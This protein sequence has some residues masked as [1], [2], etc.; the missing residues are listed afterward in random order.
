MLSPWSIQTWMYFLLLESLLFCS[1]VGF[2]PT[3]CVD[4]GEIGQRSS[5][6]LSSNYRTIRD[7]VLYHDQTKCRRFPT[8]TKRF[9]RD[10]KIFVSEDPSIVR[11]LLGFVSRSNSNDVEYTSNYVRF[12]KKNN[13]MI[14]TGVG[15][16]LVL[17]DKRR[18][19]QWTQDVAK[20]FPWIPT[21]MLSV[22]ADGLAT[23]FASVAPKDLK[24]AL[25]PGGLEKTRSK[26]AGD[27]VRNLQGQPLI[28]QLPL[29]KEEKRKLLTGLVDFSLDFLLKDVEPAMASPFDK[30]L[31]LD[32]ERREIQNYMSF[33]ELAWYRLR[34][35]PISTV[36][37]GLLTFW[38]AYAAF[39]FCRQSS[40]LA[41]IV[42]QSKSLLSSLWGIFVPVVLDGKRAIQKYVRVIRMKM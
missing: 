42:K 31:A 15:A 40:N 26:I 14:E 33:S 2:L 28:K 32:R 3:P 6:T 8:A 10:K 35:K 34:Y 29:A 38:T 18:R 22:C 16:A 23:A 25:Q 9:V 24:K 39:T 27:V 36:C 13:N 30:L 19:K 12:K 5:L 21:E 37:L 11:S 7:S 17:G 20:Q 1:C 4:R 41:T